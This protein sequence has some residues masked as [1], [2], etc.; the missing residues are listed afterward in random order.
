MKHADVSTFRGGADQFLSG[1]ERIGWEE[2]SEGKLRIGEDDLDVRASG[3]FTIAPGAS[4]LRRNARF[5]MGVMHDHPYGGH[6][7][8]GEDML[9]TLDPH[10]VVNVERAILISR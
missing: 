6:I 3:P 7:S 10:V 1:I 5:D 4:V 8:C 9:P 2:T